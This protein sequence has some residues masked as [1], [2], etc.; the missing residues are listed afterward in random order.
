[1]IDESK[2]SFERDFQGEEAIVIKDGLNNLD[3]SRLQDLLHKTGVPP[4]LFK[5]LINARCNWLSVPRHEE[6][7]SQGNKLEDI[8]FGIAKSKLGPIEIS[9]ILLYPN[10]I[11]PQDISLHLK[12]RDQR[13]FEA[14][15]VMEG[16]GT[17]Y[18]PDAA[19]PVSIGAYARSGQGINVDLKKG[20]LAFIPAPTA[21]GWVKASEGFKFRY[22]GL[23]PW[24]S[25]FVAPTI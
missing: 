12:Q 15:L 6:F 19:E 20:D 9:E 1:M 24:N 4:E 18:F 7:F 11:N 5:N 3:S 14:I 21:N 16:E 10:A 13:G 22:I 8:E 25:S 23:P 2:V 17:L